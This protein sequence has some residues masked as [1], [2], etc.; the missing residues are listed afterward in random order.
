MLT[1]RR[2]L[3]VNHIIAPSSSLPCF[4]LD[5]VHRHLGWK[6]VTGR[7]LHM[8][9]CLAPLSCM[10]KND[11]NGKLLFCAVLSCSVV[12][13]SL[14]PHGLKST[15]RLCPW[16]FSRQE[17]WSGLLFPSPGDLPDP[18][19]EPGSPALQADSLLSESPGKPLRDENY[20]L[21]MIL[22]G[23]YLIMC[24]VEYT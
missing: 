5:V 1:R 22:T 12:S 23:I 2:F 9:M 10:V 24:H 6:C 17:Y 18:G 4:L 16:G 3:Y 14:W 19:I 7:G 11:W 21:S 8:V 13:D 20:Y 15:K